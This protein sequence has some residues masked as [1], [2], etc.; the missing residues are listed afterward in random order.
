MS[1][2][3]VEQR[4]GGFYIANSRVSLESVIFCFLDGISPETIAGECFPI[5]TL[6]QAYG[7]IT[8]YLGNRVM[9]DNYLAQ[10]GTEH[11]QFAIANQ[12]DALTR[13]LQQAKRAVL[14]N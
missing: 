4:N 14:L 8:F 11:Q 7:A 5:L 13:K 9:V 2:Q 6:E 3:Y 10:V 1:N 12:N